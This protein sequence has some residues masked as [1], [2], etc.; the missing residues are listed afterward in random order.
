MFG[1]VRHDFLYMML[2]LYAIQSF[3]TTNDEYIVP[4][5]ILFGE[6]ERKSSG[7]HVTG[8]FY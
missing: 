1:N 3:D 2:V 6:M 8:F 7:S 5:Q 4:F